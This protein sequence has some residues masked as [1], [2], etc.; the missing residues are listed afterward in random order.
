M[1]LIENLSRLGAVTPTLER[2]TGALVGLS[3]EALDAGVGAASRGAV[4]ALRLV[5]PAVTK[6]EAGDFVSLVVASACNQ[7][8]DLLK[9]VHGASC[10]AVYTNSYPEAPEEAVANAMERTRICMA[11]ASRGG[12]HFDHY[13]GRFPKSRDKVSS[14]G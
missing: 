12:L 10:R 3:V 14:L 1:V 8:M 2:I 6:F 7:G 11:K 5:N 9:V 4:K 13:W